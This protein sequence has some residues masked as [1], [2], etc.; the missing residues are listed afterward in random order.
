MA[1]TLSISCR[2]HQKFGY[3]YSSYLWCAARF[4]SISYIFF[5]IFEIAG[6]GTRLRGNLF[7]L[8]YV[9]TFLLMDVSNAASPD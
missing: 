4:G 5:E 7:Q 3:K 6:Y 9:L 8:G 2:R 1:T